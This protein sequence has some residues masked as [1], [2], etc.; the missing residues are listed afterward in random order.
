MKDLIKEFKD[1]E[2]L[3]YTLNIR[4]ISSNGALEKG[5]GI[6]V[7][8]EILSLF[9][10]SFFTSLAVGAKEKVPSIRHDF[11]KNDWEAIARVLLYGY[12]STKYFPLNLSV[13]FVALCILGEEKLSND[14]LLDSFKLYVSVDEKKVIDACMNGHF[15]NNDEDTKDFL[16]SYK[17]F[18]VANVENISEI[19]FQLAHQEI[20]QRPKYIA[21]CWSTM[22]KSL[23]IFDPFKSIEGLRGMFEEKTASPKKVLKL[24]SAQPENDAE[25]E[26]F[27][28][29]KRFIKSL[30]DGALSA[31]LQ[32]TTGSDI[33][34]FDSLEVTFV[35]VDGLSRRPIAHT[36][37][38]S[39][40]LPSTYQSFNELSEEFSSLLR[41]KGF[42]EFDIV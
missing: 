4:V 10:Q 30:N 38:P 16:S 2:I 17:C 27:D 22:L 18:R 14:L 11:Q 34:I 6:G 12:I 8:R 37:T 32:F 33:I 7:T 19:I 28:H 23:T 20:V 31:F 15:D 42:W 5:E 21:T 13:A 26:S 9:W 29:L 3:N 25:R 24:L 41:E 1:K 39:L 40:E 35:N 36:C